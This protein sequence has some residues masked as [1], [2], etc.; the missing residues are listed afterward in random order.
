MGQ[1]AKHHLTTRNLIHKILTERWSEMN[2]LLFSARPCWVSLANLEMRICN[3]AAALRGQ[4]KE[5]WICLVSEKSAPYKISGSWIRKKYAT[6]C[7]PRTKAPVSSLLVIQSIMMR[8]HWWIKDEQ[9]WFRW[10]WPEPVQKSAPY[11][12]CESWSVKIC[13]YLFASDKSTTLVNER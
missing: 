5:R 7:L 13:N 1:D 11:K 9:I 3:C 2:L 10:Y 8:D 6:M 4:K 12:I